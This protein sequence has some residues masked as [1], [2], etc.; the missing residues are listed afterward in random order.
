M[1]YKLPENRCTESLYTKMPKKQ[2]DKYK[3]Y[4]KSNGMTIKDFLVNAM[5]EY[6]KRHK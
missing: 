5:D 2:V 4:A 3:E 1:G 6:M